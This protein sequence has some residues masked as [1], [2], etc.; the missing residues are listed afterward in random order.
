[1]K[2]GKRTENR[3]SRD[4]KHSDMGRWKDKRGRWKEEMV[5][6]LLLLPSSPMDL[7]PC[8]SSPL[9][10]LPLFS[11]SYISSMPLVLV[12]KALPCLALS[13]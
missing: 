1:V 10:V 2:D 12:C 8:S 9:H 5:V 4:W 13:L 6:S 7:S 3:T 11:A